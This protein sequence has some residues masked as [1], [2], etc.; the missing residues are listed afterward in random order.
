MTRR[1]PDNGIGTAGLIG[2]GVALAVCCLAP[3]LVV[4]FGTA[5]VS[6]WLIWL[7]Y[8]GLAALVLA[9]GLLG[10]VLWRWQHRGG[11][12]AAAAGNGRI[13]GRR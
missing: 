11:G 3:L 9:M 5:A 12:G 6:A 4:L 8:G 7:G 10:Y 13:E 2:A 1:K